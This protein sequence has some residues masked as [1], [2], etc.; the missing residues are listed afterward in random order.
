M[1]QQPY[2]Q[3]QNS[4]Y[5]G[6]QPVMPPQPPYNMTTDLPPEISDKPEH[7]LNVLARVIFW[8]GIVLSALF[9]VLGII[10]LISGA[11]NHHNYGYGYGY[12]YDNPASIIAAGGGISLIIMSIFFAFMTVLAWA[13][14]RV[15]SN[16]SLTTKAIRNKIH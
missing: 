15:L 6:Q 7:T 5:Y 8:V 12:G 14:L 4:P 11:S 9:F 16:I 10:A 1:E 3:P 13:Q 2:N